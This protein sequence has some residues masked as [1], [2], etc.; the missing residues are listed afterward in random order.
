LDHPN[1]S[2]SNDNLIALPGPQVLVLMFRNER[3]EVAI[4]GVIVRGP[5]SAEKNIVDSNQ[6]VLG[7]TISHV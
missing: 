3:S 5:A 7:A 1:D 2:A 6:A 4:P